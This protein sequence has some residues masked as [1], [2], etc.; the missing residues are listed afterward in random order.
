MALNKLQVALLALL[1]R[2]SAPHFSRLP[3]S[4]PCRCKLEFA[5]AVSSLTAERAFVLLFAVGIYGRVAS[6]S[7]R[8]FLLRSASL[9]DQFNKRSGIDGRGTE[10]L[11]LCNRLP[12]RCRGS[13]RHDGAAWRQ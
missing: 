13:S 10:I 7:L 9:T 1:G 6:T 5:P 2:R 11:P 8:Q 4:R 3:A 12:L